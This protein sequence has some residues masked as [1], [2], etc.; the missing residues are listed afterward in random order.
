MRQRVRFGIILISFI[1][2]PVTF[3]YFSPYLIIM[4]ASEK[5]INGSFIVF[6]A[7]FLSSLF[8]G[9]AFCGWLCP[10]AG[11]QEACFKVRNR[12]VNNRY[13]WIRYIIWVPWIGLIAYMAVAA[14]GLTKVD[15]A[16]RTEYGISVSSIQSLIIYFMVLFPIAIITL[17]VGNR[18][19]CHYLCWM[20]PFMIAGRKIRNLFKWPSLRLKA[21]KQK[22]KDCLKCN[23]VCPMSL[24][25]YKM[26]QAETMKNSECILCGSCVDNCPENV[27]SYSFSKGK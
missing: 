24:D 26:V 12:K 19:V 16:Y 14:G 1:L 21:D 25:V 6:G 20:S 13:N 18:A 27:I 8:I 17:A 9:R 11:F 3:Y 22:C 7:L 4:G 2:M 23:E 10:L 5:V 15:F